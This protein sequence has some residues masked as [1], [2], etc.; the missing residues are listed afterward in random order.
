MMIP[1]M[2]KKIMNGNIQVLAFEKGTNTLF[3]SYKWY[4][5]IYD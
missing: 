4:H 5:Y 1:E 2:E 3:W